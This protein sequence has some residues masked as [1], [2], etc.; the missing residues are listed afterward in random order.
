MR[1]SL[2]RISL[3][4]SIL[5]VPA[6]ALTVSATPSEAA[7]SFRIMTWN[8]QDNGA[9]DGTV[10]HIV[11]QRADIVAL[12]EVCQSDA[13]KLADR[14]LR[15]HGLAYDVQFG[16]AEDRPLGC[17]LRG[18]FGQAI[19]AKRS[20]SMKRIGNYVYPKEPADRCDTFRER[21]AFLRVQVTLSERTVDVANTHLGLGDEIYCQLDYLLTYA[22]G[23]SNAIITGDFNIRHTDA[24][25]TGFHRAGYT[26]IDIR[27]DEPGCRTDFTFK[28]DPASSTANP[29]MKIDFIWVKGV[30]P[31]G[32][33][34]TAWN[35][36][37][38]HRALTGP[39]H[40][41]D[42]PALPC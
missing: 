17:Y 19:L 14:L 20:L 18:P 9:A 2:A 13:Q 34:V 21:R 8:T 27:P 30:R 42:G 24:A 31:A 37:S 16:K 3:I 41:T 26:E 7:E 15:E 36:V 25:L 29:T 39:V 10:T 35:R 40:A 5:C 4:L 28:N 38:D 6:I 11:E 1:I 32:P 22:A 23:W 12:Q 33:A